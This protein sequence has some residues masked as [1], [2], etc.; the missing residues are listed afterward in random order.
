MQPT[1]KSP[2]MKN[3]LKYSKSMKKDAS[4]ESNSKSGQAMMANISPDT[5]PITQ[6]SKEKKG[7]LGLSGGNSTCRTATSN[8]MNS[9]GESSSKSGKL[10]IP[11]DLR[12]EYSSRTI[13]ALN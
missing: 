13:E 3:H 11:S 8:N 12:N 1:A 6:S 4:M 7:S 2:R 10:I 9:N 5:T